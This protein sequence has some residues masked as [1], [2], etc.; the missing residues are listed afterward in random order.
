MA[1]IFETKDKVGF[2]HYFTVLNILD[3]R[4]YHGLYSVYL[5]SYA[6]LENQFDISPEMAQEIFSE[7]EKL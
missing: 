3:V 5:N 1:K 7:M 6:N 2:K 4:E